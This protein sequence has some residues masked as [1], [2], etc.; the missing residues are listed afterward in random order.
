MRP[1]LAQ[2]AGFS[3]AAALLAFLRWPGF[4]PPVPLNPDEAQMLAQAITLIHH[5]VPW[6]SYDPTTSGPLNSMLLAVPLLFGGKPGY[7]AGR[8]F[9]VVLELGALACLYFTLRRLFGPALAW[10]ACLLPFAFF[11]ALATPE[12][13]NYTSEHLSLLL[14]AWTGY[15]LACFAT[16]AGPRAVVHAGK[17]G[18]LAGA[19]PFAKLQTAPFV[20]W[21]VATALAILVVRRKRL[22]TFRSK[23]L[24]A[25]ALGLAAVPLLVLVPVTLSGSLRDFVICY[26]V[27]PF[28]YVRYA[29]SALGGS[30]SVAAYFAT[31][32]FARFLISASAV[33]LACGAGTALLAAVERRFPARAAL[34]FLAAAA[35]LV[36]ASIVAIES[37]R[38]SFQHYLLFLVLPAAA[39]SAGSLAVL[40]TALAQVSAVRARAVA[41]MLVVV[42]TLP[43]V[44]LRSTSDPYAAAGWQPSAQRAAREAVEAML[45]RRVRPGD[46]LAIW[47]WM[48]EYFV[49]TDA[50][51]GTRDSLSEFQI[52]RHPFQAYYRAR[53]VRDFDTNR[54]AFFLD[55]VAPSSAAFTSRADA[56][57]ETFPELAARVEAGYRL[58]GESGGVR[59]YR[60]IER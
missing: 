50:V 11:C 21:A 10:A 59:L 38:S 37:P 45:T 60:R 44:A 24:L 17:A 1:A 36:V 55:T 49:A 43:L 18:L 6:H 9:A 51:M 46:S 4:W 14:I 19:L 12:W 34:W 8:M 20:L 47:G 35:A 16:A 33:A 5:P 15:E 7:A 48:P 41:A 58:A 22:A 29:E 32:E 3:A 23:T 54:P 53:Y 57:F 25:L 27:F 28:T 39:F 52:A 31:P 30:L 26:V 42:A 2:A 13:V 40:T 56:G